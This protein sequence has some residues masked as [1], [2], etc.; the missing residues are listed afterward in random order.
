MPFNPNKARLK[1]LLSEFGYN[2]ESE[3]K[4]IKESQKDNIL[5]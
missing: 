2:H 5:F 1:K 4:T 3:M